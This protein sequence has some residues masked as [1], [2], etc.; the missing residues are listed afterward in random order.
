M[1]T[2]TARILKDHYKMEVKAGKNSLIADEPVEK[3]GTES[4]FS[5]SELLLASLGACTSITL[6]MFADRK[7]WELEE[8]NVHLSLQRDQEKN[9]TNIVRNIELTGTLSL[10]QRERLLAVANK[11]PTH[12]ILTNPILIE[13]T[14]V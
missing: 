14:I 3:G 4:G 1:V 8:V 13:T 11:C 7:E 6:R 2:V 9:V 5:P 12:Q 10:E